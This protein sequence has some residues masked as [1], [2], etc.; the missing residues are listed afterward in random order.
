MNSGASD[1][2]YMP[3]Q[4][5]I[6]SRSPDPCNRPL[7]SRLENSALPLQEHLLV[8]IEHF[9]FLFVLTSRWPRKYLLCATDPTLSMCPDLGFQICYSFRSCFFLIPFKSWY[10]S[11]TSEIQLHLIWVSLS[12]DNKQAGEHWV[13][14]RGV[15]DWTRSSEFLSIN[16]WS[17]GIDY[18]VAS[19]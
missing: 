11:L 17:F 5:F 7:S 15:C 6:R 2:C 14:Y 16:S 13:W 19:I 4:P 8:G 1:M 3:I 18:F 10:L 9:N 12:K